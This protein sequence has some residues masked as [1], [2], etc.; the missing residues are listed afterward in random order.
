[1]ARDTLHIAL[2][3]AVNKLASFAPALKDY[4]LDRF[5]ELVVTLAITAAEASR[6]Y[7]FYLITGDGQ[8]E[9][10]LVHFPQIAAAGAAKL[11]ARLS[12]LQLPQTIS[13]AQPGVAT[14][15]SGIISPGS[16]HAPK[17]L[18]AGMVAH[19]PWGNMLR[20]EL[21]CAGGALTTGITYTLQIQARE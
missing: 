11:T 12:S 19:G 15:T 7:D 5:S 10:D 6:T 3:A 13:A 1:M 4:R 9:W 2:D 18:G 16:T 20:Y 8:A 14:V 17:T 21:V